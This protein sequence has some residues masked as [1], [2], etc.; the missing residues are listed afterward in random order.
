MTCAGKLSQIQTLCT[1][2]SDSVCTQILN[3]I[4]NS[5]GSG[6]DDLWGEDGSTAMVWQ[7][8]GIG[9]LAVWFCYWV[10]WFWMA[11]GMGTE[12]ETQRIGEKAR[13]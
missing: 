1:S 8:F 11:G 4:S 2:S 10:A 3:I 6:N 13:R 7:I 5:T 12:V 9:V